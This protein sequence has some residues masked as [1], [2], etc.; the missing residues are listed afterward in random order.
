MPSLRNPVGPLPSSIY[1][2][3]RVVVLTVLAAVVALLSWLVF[4]GGGKK[5]A[6]AGHPG[7]AQSI[8]PG[9]TGS[10]GS[11]SGGSSDGSTTGGPGKGGRPTAGAS[12]TS[13]GGSVT[14]TG[15]GSGGSSSGG[16]GS[17]VANSA[18]TMGLPVCSASDL[19]LSLGSTQQS[20][21][22]TQWP[23]F[24]LQI[25]NT[26]GTA[27]RADLGAASAVAVVSTSGNGHVWSSGDCPLN[28]AAEWYTV[29]ASGSTLT[30]NFQWSRTTSAPGCTPGAGGAAADPGTYVVQV[31]LKGLTAEP[32]TQFRLAPF[33]S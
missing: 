27:C 20:Y 9:P 2:R 4:G 13:G 8:T 7:P 29:P 11:G 15:G 23:V 3:R 31:S 5:T 18:A 16:S 19:S 32:S 33:G 1:W 12:A 25:G 22:A 26:S 21:N 14:V 6:T 28:T 24:Q 17:T 10:S 30:A